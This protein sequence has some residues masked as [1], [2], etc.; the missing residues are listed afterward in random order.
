MTRKWMPLAMAVAMGMPLALRAQ[1]TPRPVRPA[2]APRARV[3]ERAGEPMMTYTFSGNRARLG[4]LVNTAANADSDKIGARLAAVTPG[5]PAAKAGLKA[6]DVITKFN[7]TALAG[8][9]AEDEEESGPGHKLI[10]LAHDLDVGDTVQVEYRRGADTKKATIIAEEVEGGGMMTL[11]RSGEHGF[12]F[13]TPPMGELAPA[14]PWITTPRLNERGFSFCFGDSWCDLDL[15][16]LNPDLGEYFGTSEGL[17]VVKAPGDSS[18]ALKSGD[19]I[20]SI[21]GRKPTSAEHAMRILR[22]YDAG[23]TVTI[24]IMRKQ[25]RTTLSW[26][27]PDRDEMLRT[28][29]PRRGTRGEPSEFRYNVMP[30]IRAEVLATTAARTRVRLI[31]GLKRSHLRAI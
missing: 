22:S 7:G 23:E 27:V 17:L 19:V 14:M 31:Q 21:G 4:V 24:D 10:E 9:S 16:R 20:L 28:R 29:T 5:G 30:K 6:G 8:E 2:P 13:T 1:E 26:K 25:R 15:V 18:L 12:T 3:R 11:G